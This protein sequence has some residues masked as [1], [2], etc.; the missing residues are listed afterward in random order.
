VTYLPFTMS[1]VR[2][3]QA[4]P[5]AALCDAEMLRRAIVTDARIREFMQRTGLSE[6]EIGL[7]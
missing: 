1:D 3:Y 2:R 6:A 5:I 7:V 4:D